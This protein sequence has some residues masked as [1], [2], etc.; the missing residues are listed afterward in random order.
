LT[1]IP[2]NNAS[3]Q[4]HIIF[5][6]VPRVD[7]IEASVIHCSSRVRTFISWRGDGAEKL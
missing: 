3:E 6:P 7:G 4:Q 5:D 1:K 2:A